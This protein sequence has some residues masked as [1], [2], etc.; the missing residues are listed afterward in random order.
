MPV[1]VL[2]VVTTHN[3]IISTA[4]SWQPLR[5]KNFSPIFLFQKNIFYRDSFIWDYLTWL[6]PLRTHFNIPPEGGILRP[7]VAMHF[8][9]G[10]MS[11]ALLYWIYLGM[12]DFGSLRSHL[13]NT[14][15]LT[16]KNKPEN[17]MNL[18]W[19]QNKPQ[20]TFGFRLTV[21]QKKSSI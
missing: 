2:V 18:D 10:S 19:Q 1:Q 9:G 11:L 20:K 16:K 14:P 7:C 6:T 15:P 3:S 17:L 21:H 5:K 4:Q 12:E 8:W 13:E